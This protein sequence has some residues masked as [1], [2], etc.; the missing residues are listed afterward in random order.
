MGQSGGPTAVINAS[1]A[2]VITAARG[3]GFGVQ[4]RILGMRFAVEGFMKEQMLDL[5]GISAAEV[6]RLAHTPGSALG[7]CRYKLQDEDLPRIHSVLKKYNI[8]YLLYI[9]GNDTMDTIHRISSY[10]MEQGYEL[11]G[12]GIPKTVDNDLH[13]TDHTPGYA[14]AARYVAL[15]VQQAGRLA[16]DMQMV[17]NFCGASNSGQRSWLAC[18]SICTGEAKPKRCPAPYISTRAAYYSRAGSC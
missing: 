1:L 4:N 16:C 3:A 11:Q 15:S 13:A 12:I 9:G 10:C 5:G 2:G 18:R 17:D 14:S 8:R 6:N 7:S